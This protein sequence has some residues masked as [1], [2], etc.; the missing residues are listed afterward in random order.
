MSSG[1]GVLLV[2]GTGLEWNRGYMMASAAERA[3]EAG[4][5]LWLLNGTKP[6][7]QQPYI[8]G[9]S[10]LN[11]FDHDRLIATAHEVASQHP[12]VAV[13]GWDEPLVIPTARIADMLGVPGLGAVGVMNCRDKHRTRQLLT[14]AGLPQPRFALSATADEARAAAAAIGY[15]VVVKPRALGASIGV[16]LAAD[17][18]E[19]NAA[20]RVAED[21][22][23]AGDE[24]F[25]GGALVEEY[26][27]GPEVSIDAAVFKGEYLPMYVAHKTVG[28]HPYFEEL[29]HVVDAADPLLADEA[30]LDVL[31]T[32]HRVLAVENGITHTEVK[33]TERGPLIVEV[34]GRPGGDLITYIGLLAT[35]IDAGRALVDIETG[36]RPDVTAHQSRTVGVRFGYPEQNLVVTSITPPAP[37]PEHGLVRAEALVPAG[38]ELRLPP[39]GYL[40]RHSFVVCTADNPTQCGQRLDTAIGAVRVV[41]DPV[42][43]PP[44]GTPF[45]MPE[46]LLD[47]DEE[48]DQDPAP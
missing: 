35:G 13:L 7:W 6:T 30:F 25:R 28:M 16:V 42:A 1:S 23:F 48:T 24:P 43:P 2:L 4:Y 18:A 17:E 12:V 11:V 19:L 3:A 22:G 39:G 33:L 32:A 36:T 10:V 34:N 45:V 29:G 47:V 44:V 21:A 9:S 31:V 14:A 37:D 20:F 38:T 40:A 5:G 46:G 27:A 15:P 8:V 26:I 41:G